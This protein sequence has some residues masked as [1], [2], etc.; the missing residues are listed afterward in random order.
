MCNNK[1]QLGLA[2]GGLLALIHAVWALIVATGYGQILL[3]WI[4]GLHMISTGFAVMPFSWGHA[5]I[6]IIVTFIVGY[7]IGWLLA[8]IWNW[9]GST[10]AKKRRR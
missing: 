6:L 4:F 5:L 2:V 10:C 9:A 3:D 1:N 8:A 7:I